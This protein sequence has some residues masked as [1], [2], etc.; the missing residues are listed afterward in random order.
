[1]K[2]L[3]IILLFL[4][5]TFLVG[6]TVFA[7]SDDATVTDETVS[8]QTTTVQY[9]LNYEDYVAGNWQT[10]GPIEVTTYSRAR[11]FWWGGKDFR[12]QSEDKDV[13]KLL[14]KKAFAILHEG[15]LL[16][17]T[18]TFKD[19]GT[20]F[21]SGYAR[22]LPTTD[23]RFVLLYYNVKSLNMQVAM[24]GGFFGMVG[25]LTVG[26][27]N[28]QNMKSN[29]CYLITPGE[30]KALIINDKMMTQLTTEANQPDLM[31]KYMMFESKDE[32][33]SAYHVIPILEEL[34]IVQNK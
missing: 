32:R 19:R 31:T 6:Q 23:G 24:A 2:R 5:S 11:Q 14:K 30:K 26:A 10:I 18:R 8:S 25:G 28:N 20:R 34:G 12:F 22:A 17:N 16:L 29:V 7:Q 15:T 1:M 33:M 27:L 9:C 3:T 13:E 4:V 21:R